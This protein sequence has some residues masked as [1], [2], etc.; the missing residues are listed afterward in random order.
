MHNLS[1]KKKLI[2]TILATFACCLALSTAIINNQNYKIANTAENSYQLI[3]DKT[4]NPLDGL[5][6]SYSNKDVYQKTALGNDINIIYNNVATNSNDENGYLQMRNGYIFN[7]SAINGI[8]SITIT[9]NCNGISFSILYDA[10]SKYSYSKSKT[11]TSSSSTPTTFDFDN[12]YPNYFRIRSTDTTS[13]LKIMSIVINYSC[14]NSYVNVNAA[15]ASSSKGTVSGTANYK[16]G[17]EAT[18]TATPKTGYDFIGWFDE[19]NQ[20]VSDQIE[21]TFTV[22]GEV[23]YTAKFDPKPYEFTIANESY[24]R[25]YV[26][27]SSG[28]YLYKSDVTI[29]A[30]AHSGYVFKGWYNEDTLVSDENPYTFAMPA[31]NYTLTAKYYTEEE[32]EAVQR[33]ISLGIR[34]NFNADK[35]ELTYGLYPQTLVT[36]SSLISKLNSS[37]QGTTYSNGWKG[38]S[39]DFYASV[40]TTFGD[41]DTKFNNGDQVSNN[42]KY[43]F[44]C[45]AINWKILSKSDSNYTVTSSMLLDVNLFY[46]STED[47]GTVHANNFAYSTILAWLNSEDKSSYSA[48]NF[49]GSGFYSY[50][51]QYNSDYVTTTSYSLKAATTNSSNNTYAVNTTRTDN[52]TLP[53]YADLKNSS[54]GFDS[55]D[56][57][58]CKGT[59]YAIAKG[60]YINTETNNGYYFTRSPDYSNA[61]LVSQINGSGGFGT[62]SVD[63]YRGIRPMMTF[64][65]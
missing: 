56:A 54:Y 25:G 20:M 37:N 8:E 59:D 60:L 22:E 38:Y 43:W 36:D 17:S 19:N 1:Q 2:P 4:N 9:T 7:Y 21:Y 34:P 24:E 42:T 27:D 61:H 46:G 41:G 48:G 65:I 44:K 18:F 50:A 31:E 49:T 30:T 14:T 45:E 23:T 11:F 62:I 16:I 35:T 5:T 29:S 39:G 47:R 64:A 33:E 15:T 6:S 10:A 40:T 28:T 55:N 58:K 53:S 63:M 57:R 51:F 12:D 3:L 52:V 26:S 13:I 32:A